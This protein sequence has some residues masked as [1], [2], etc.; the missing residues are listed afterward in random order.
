MTAA[1][2]A[3]VFRDRD[4]VLIRDVHYPYRVEQIEVLAG[5]MTERAA[6]EWSFASKNAYFVG[7]Q[8][9]DMELTERVG[10]QGMLDSRSYGSR[11]E[12]LAGA[13]CRTFDNLLPAARWI[14]SQTEPVAWGK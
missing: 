1:P 11:S 7:D 12:V 9:G 14:V 10:A 5:A 4:E 6:R 13:Q 8:A 2:S 3:V